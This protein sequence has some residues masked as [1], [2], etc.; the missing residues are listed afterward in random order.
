VVVA[1]MRF[2]FAGAAGATIA[3]AAVAA[4]PQAERVSAQV[5]PNVNNILRSVYFIDLLLVMN[6]FLIRVGSEREELLIC[7]FGKLYH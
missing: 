4:V 3:G 1:R 2:G 5:S 7:S 6:L